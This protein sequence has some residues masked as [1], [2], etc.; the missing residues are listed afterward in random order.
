MC[1]GKKT[2]A[3]MTRMYINEYLVI[4]ISSFNVIAFL[5]LTFSYLYLVLVFCRRSAEDIQD[6][7]LR[8][9][10]QRLIGSSVKDHFEG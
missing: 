7:R 1:L 2:A 4:F 3:R 6:I 10:R 9:A 5:S 8:V